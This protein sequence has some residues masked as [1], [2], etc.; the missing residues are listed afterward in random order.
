MASESRLEL[1]LRV[2]L[3]QADIAFEQEFR[4]DPTRRYRSDFFIPGG[5][6]LVEIEG[7]IFRGDVGHN[8]IGGIKR[9]IEK[10]ALAVSLGYTVLR[11]HSDQVT[12]GDAL[13]IIRQV[14]GVAA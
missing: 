10:Q 12:H 8:S 5:N 6:L 4:F 14:L 13:A 3:E 1:T 9:D 2:Q 11:V 7:G